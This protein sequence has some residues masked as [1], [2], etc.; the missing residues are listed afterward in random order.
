MDRPA[1][2]ERGPPDGHGW[3]V[4]LRGVTETVI[5][6]PNADGSWNQAAFG[7]HAGEPPWGRT[8]GETTTHQNLGRDK[9]GVLQFPTDPVAV[10]T[11]ALDAY[12]TD[13]PVLTTAAAW[14][15]VEASTRKRGTDGG[16]AWTEWALTPAAHGVRKRAVPTLRRARTAVIEAAVAASRLDVEAYDRDRLETVLERTATLVERTGTE[17]ERAAIDRIAALTDWPGV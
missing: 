5:A 1:G 3:P 11:A 9:T 12:V 4:T 8:W 10:V 2:K 16:T 15:T 6:T 14:V 7:V 13:G 17:R